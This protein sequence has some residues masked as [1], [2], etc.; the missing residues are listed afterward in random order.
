[1]RRTRIISTVG[2]ATNSPQFLR[3]LILAGTDAFRLNFSH[4]TREEHAAVCVRIRSAAAELDRPIAILQDL[5]GPKIRIGALERPIDLTAGQVLTIEYHPDYEHPAAGARVTTAFAAL[6]TSVER[7]ARLLVDE[8]RI[9]LEV[10]VTGAH[11]IET[12]VLTP[13]RLD[14]HK[15]IN[16]PG[17]VLQTP[18]MTE[19]DEA[20]LRAGVAMGVDVVGVSFV[21]TADDMR[22]VRAAAAAAGAPDL[23]LVAKIEKPLAVDRIDE[24]IEQSDGLMV[25]RGDLGIEMPLE[26]IPAVQKRLI[27]VARDHGVPVTV[28]TQVLESMRTSPR[29][30]RAE[31]TDAAHAVDEGADA[32]MLAGETAIGKFPVESVAT[33]DRILRE[34]ERAP[35]APGA[36]AHLHA[37][38]APHARALCEAAVALASRAGAA[39][40]VAVTE[41]G[42]TARLL[43]ALRPRARILAATSTREIAARLNIIWGVTPFVAPTDPAQPF[44]VVARRLL[45]DRGLVAPGSVVVFVSIGTGL[46]RSDANFVHVETL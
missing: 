9:E 17:V 19:K 22:R 46:E 32:V 26:V 31:V 6:F 38:W 29:P 33:L 15:G 37:D 21:Q 7:G 4:G 2:P 23:P 18:A 39:A 27:G 10:L 5:A 1:M 11:R 34:A 13:G 44:L 8:G 35:A 42:R 25:A 14:S 24:I 43:S 30:T 45:I 28:A 12:R 20:D 41:G 40:I 36:S 16:V 3:S